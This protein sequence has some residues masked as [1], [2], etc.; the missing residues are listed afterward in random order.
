MEDFRKKILDWHEDQ[1]T[2]H[3]SQGWLVAGT[4]VFV[5]SVGAVF[6]L[7][8]WPWATT[9]IAIALFLILLRSFVLFFSK[10]RDLYDWIYFIGRVTLMLALAVNFTFLPLSKHILFAS[11]GLFA[12]SAITFFFKSKSNDSINEAEDD[13]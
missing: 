11:L 12:I 5:F 8:Q 9:M 2:K 10:V 3:W 13:Y 6:K 1:P 7:M 4:P